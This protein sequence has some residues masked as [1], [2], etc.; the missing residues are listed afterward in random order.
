LT[1]VPSFCWGTYPAAPRTRSAGQFST[2][3]L[4]RSVAQ[5]TDRPPGFCILPLDRYRLIPNNP[6]A[7]HRSSLALVEIA[8]ANVFLRQHLPLH[9]AEVPV[10]R[11]KEAIERN[12]SASRVGKP[13]DNRCRAVVLYPVANPHPPGDWPRWPRRIIFYTLPRAGADD[14]FGGRCPESGDVP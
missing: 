4:C 7:G 8:R 6:P 11:D 5:R 14:L 1:A 3:H 12:F 10:I 2:D 9:S 13:T